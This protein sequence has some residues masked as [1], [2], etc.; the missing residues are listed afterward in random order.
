MRCDRC[1][2]LHAFASEWDVRVSFELGQILCPRCY[3]RVGSW[4]DA[5]V[6]SR[7]AERLRGGHAP[8]SP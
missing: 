3:L 1:H 5:E 7:E 2:R 4:R 6:T 8:A